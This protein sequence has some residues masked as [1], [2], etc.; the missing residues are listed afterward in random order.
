MTGTP[1]EQLNPKKKIFEQIQP[2]LR[3]N[4]EGVAS[5]KGVPWKVK[6]FD[7][8]CT[9]PTMKDSPIK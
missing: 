5:Y 6:G 3:I 7:G 4:S 9:V 1:D 8:Y 2:D